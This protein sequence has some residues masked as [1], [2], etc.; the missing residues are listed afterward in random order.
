[1]SQQMELTITAKDQASKVIEGV[2]K[3]VKNFGQQFGQQLAG[4][5]APMALVGVAMAKISEHIQKVAQQRKEAFDWGASLEAS[6]N[7]IGISVEAFQAV[8]AAA[9]ATGESV[10]RVGKSFKL[11]SDLIAAARSGNK[12]AA[13]ALAALGIKLADLEK[14]SPQDILRRLAAALATT[15]DPAKR[16]QLA[17]AAL[18]KSAAELQDVLAKGFDIAGAIEGTEGLT[19]AEANFL[20]E[21]A[22]EERAKKNRE[23]LAQARQQAT[24]RFLEQD[25]QG[26]AILAAEQERLRRIVGPMAGRG[27]VGGAGLTAGVAA[28]DPRVQ[29]L[30]QEALEKARREAEAG[31]PGPDAAAAAALAK[32]AEEDAKKA[33][34]AAEKESKKKPKKGPST[35]RDDDLGVFEKSQPTVSSL[36]AIGGGM[37]GE[38]AGLVDFQRNSLEVQKQIRDILAEIKNRGNIQNTDFTKPATGPSNG[39]YVPPIP[40]PSRPS[41]TGSSGTM[42]A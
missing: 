11:A 15:E 33:A 21:Q 12:D 1:M 7:K 30:V 32:R 18:G 22:R 29:A 2:E 10:D 42:L 25:P 26:R 39:G 13:E 5:V 28:A 24:Q 16:A 31:K 41:L 4:L 34:E 36:R 23:R 3:R 9:D 17:I 19:T 35:K 14:T 38:V 8:E 6:A 20:R 27:G 37:A 40:L